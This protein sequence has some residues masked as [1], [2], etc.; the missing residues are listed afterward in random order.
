MI[1]AI[2]GGNWGDEGKG[3][4]TD[5]FAADADYVIRFQGGA[6]AGH[7]IINQY[8]KNVLHILPSGV[9]QE[10]TVNIIGPGA[11]FNVERFRAEL[12]DV[13]K[14][15]A[16]T[17]RIL[18]S[19]RAQLVMPYHILFDKLEEQRLGK[20][21]FGSTQSGIAPHYADKA[22]KIGFQL[23]ELY[24]ANLAEK[25]ERVCIIKNATIKG[26]YPDAN[27]LDPKEILAY[28]KEVG[29]FI[30]PYLC[31]M[32][33]LMREAVKA[34][35][36][37]VLE[38]QLGALRDITNGIYPMTTSSSTLAG[39]GAVGACLPPHAIKRVITVVKA[40]SSC[41]GAGPFT[42][43][44]FGEEADSL[45]KKGG[46]DGEFGATTGRPRRM[47]WFDAVATK[48]GVSVQGTTDVALSLIDVLGYFDEI[49]VCVAYDVNGT[50][51]TEFPAGDRLE[52]A[53]PI[54]EKVPGW[55][56]DIK[57]VTE[58][59]ALPQA[60]KDYV[61]YIEKLIDCPITMISTG[62]D[63]KDMIYRK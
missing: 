13:K 25:V 44:I 16:P 41:V 46:S 18:V 60:A 35:K 21:S 31:N 9:F 59:D 19:D 45:R 38:G 47:G 56:C 55:K 39:Y 4:L 15:G 34:D 40:Y 33:D 1:T 54:Y 58:W 11:A 37:I 24:N 2:V 50:R 26:L 57:G 42:T 10:G 49:P 6:N 53:K 22:M 20:N 28:L 52:I 51:T 17:P 7:T 8:G 14:S 30:K 27:L 32:A 3:K 48:Y 36:N 5:V 63:R 12:E 23:A 43:E 61:E 29:T 62:P